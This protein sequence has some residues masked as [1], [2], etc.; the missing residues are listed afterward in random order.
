[1]AAS[2]IYNRSYYFSLIVALLIQQIVFAE[3]TSLGEG[4]LQAER[5][6]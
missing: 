6:S 4:L 2:V 3:T 1:M 5:R